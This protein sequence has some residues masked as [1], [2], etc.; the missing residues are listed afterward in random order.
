MQSA[1]L[2]QSSD[3]APAQLQEQ[4]PCA[5]RQI[6]QSSAAHWDPS[7][8][9][10]DTF[11]RGKN[12]TEAPEQHQKPKNYNQGGELGPLGQCVLLEFSGVV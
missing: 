7:L 12:Y 1:E 9:L 11:T 5:C 6:P 4:G 2:T 3:S 8:S 10:S